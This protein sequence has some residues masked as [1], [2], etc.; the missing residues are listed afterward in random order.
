MAKNKPT[1]RKQEKHQQLVGWNNFYY[2]K[3]YR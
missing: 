3:W 2:K 1:K